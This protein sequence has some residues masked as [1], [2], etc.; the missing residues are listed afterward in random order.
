MSRLGFKIILLSNLKIFFLESVTSAKKQQP[1]VTCTTPSH[2][3]L[4][5]ASLVLLFLSLSFFCF[6][7]PNPHFLLKS[8][9]QIHESFS[10]PSNN[11]I[12]SS[13]CHLYLFSPKHF[14]NFHSLCVSFLPC[15]FSPDPEATANYLG[16]SGN[17]S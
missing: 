11:C 1:P 4:F 3:F 10:I 9:K 5:Y 14:I 6:T 8:E 13:K 16:G 17:S 15:P 12:L 2:E 7:Y